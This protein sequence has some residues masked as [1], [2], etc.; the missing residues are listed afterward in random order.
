MLCDADFKERHDLA[1]RTISQLKNEIDALRAD[2]RGKNLEIGDL[3]SDEATLNAQLDQRTI[4]IEKLKNELNS[5]LADNEE[6]L[7][8]RM[9]V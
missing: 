4:E 1:L 9:R 2:L 3:E 6:L 8:E 7:N 5:L